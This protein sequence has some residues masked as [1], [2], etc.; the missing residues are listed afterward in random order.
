MNVIELRKMLT[1]QLEAVKSDPSQI[2]TA[3]AMAT[4]AVRITGSAA[5]EMQYAKMHGK[6]RR[7]EFLEDKP[8][9]QRGAS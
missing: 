9:K 6:K 1:E 7:I 8:K 4:L 2:K 3:N 5:L